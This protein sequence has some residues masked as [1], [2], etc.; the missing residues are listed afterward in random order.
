MSGIPNL[1]LGIVMLAG[2]SRQYAFFSSQAAR[3]WAKHRAYAGRLMTWC[4]ILPDRELVEVECWASQ[5]GD[6]VAQRELLV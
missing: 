3:K 4:P 2:S 5:L 6:L 1:P